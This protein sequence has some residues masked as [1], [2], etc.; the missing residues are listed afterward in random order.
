MASESDL[1]HLADLGTFDPPAD[2]PAARVIWEDYAIRLNQDLPESVVLHKD[3]VIGSRDGRPLKAD[4]S[5]P[6]NQTKSNKAKP[7]VVIY[8][9]GGGWAFGS[10]TSFRKLGMNFAQH[11]FVCVN[12]DYSL[13]P[14]FP[15]P[16]ALDDILLA[17]DA[18]TD[19]LAEE[20]GM[21]AYKIV[22]AGDS[23]GGNLASAAAM[24]LSYESDPRLDRIKSLLLF[25][26]VYDLAGALER[27]NH[28][29]G[30]T[31]QVKSYVGG[32]DNYPAG[33]EN[34]LVSPLGA[35]G[36]LL[37]SN[38]PACFILEGGNDPVVGGEGK[39]LFDALA[40]SE[41]RG[42]KVEERHELYVVPG[43]PHGFMQMFG[44]A[45]CAEGWKRTL[46]F[47]GRKVGANTT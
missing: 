42:K 27:A 19:R 39:R 32:P 12:L 23:A 18:I 34:P 11:G 10:P 6:K 40:S 38:L 4:I 20:F 3:V 22:L 25:Y 31:L 43:M 37:P 24:K 7:P 36:K 1:K 44:L 45:G 47:L 41:K 15:F 26:G 30:L 17:V 28:H 5:I 8:L 33:L 35:H 2:I 21:D 29:P 14:E 16:R 13:A 9:H 46:D